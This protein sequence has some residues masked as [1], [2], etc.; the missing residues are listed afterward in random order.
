MQKRDL[1][2]AVIINAVGP[3]GPIIPEQLSALSPLNTIQAPDCGMN[4]DT[5]RSARHGCKLPAS[6]MA[7]QQR[8]ISDHNNVRR[9]PR[10]SPYR[11]NCTLIF[12]RSPPSVR[13][14]SPLKNSSHRSF[15]MRADLF[16]KKSFRKHL[17]NR[18]YSPLAYCF[19]FRR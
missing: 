17:R 6:G 9:L 8:H 4:C 13:K 18:T 10:G 12:L 7:Q 16:P 14:L 2:R 15:V 1:V 3:M 5:P 19:R 11:A